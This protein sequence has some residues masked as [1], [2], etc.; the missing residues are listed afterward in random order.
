MGIEMKG[1]YVLAK[2]RMPN[3]RFEATAAVCAPWDLVVIC[4]WALSEVI[5]GTPVLFEPHVV[6]S[7]YVAEYRNYYWQHRKGGG[8]LGITLS[9]ATG[10]YPTTKT[11]RIHDVAAKDSGRNFGR[12]ARTKAMHPFIDMILRNELAGIPLDAW[13]RFL[14]I[15]VEGVTTDTIESQLSQIAANFASEP[16]RASQIVSCLDELASLVS[17][18]AA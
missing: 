14:A 5:S 10:Y 15:F 3:F 6:P 13:N 2:E 11:T 4:P 18:S 8:D 16:E 12:Y 1:W 7:R 17:Q 9:T